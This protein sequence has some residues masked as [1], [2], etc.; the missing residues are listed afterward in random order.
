MR[1]LLRQL[2]VL[3]A[4]ISCGSASAQ[5]SHTGARLR[6][7]SAFALPGAASIINML[8]NPQAFEGS[9]WV[10]TNISDTTFATKTMAPDGT[11]TAEKLIANTERGLHYVSYGNFA[12]AAHSVIYRLMVDAKPAEYSRLNISYAD[13]N[14]GSGIQMVC[15]FA[16]VRVG[17]APNTFGINGSSFSANGSPQIYRIGNGFARCIMDV[18]TDALGT[19][20]VSIVVDRGTGRGALNWSFAGN[21]SKGIFVWQA[22]LL[23]KAVW[24]Q[25]AGARTFF[26]PMTSSSTFDL[27]NSKA[28]GYNWY[29]NNQWPNAGEPA[30]LGYP[31]SFWRTTTPTSSGNLSFGPGGVTIATDVSPGALNDLSTSVTNNITVAT[32]GTTAAG[33]AILHFASV[34]GSI[35]A[36]MQVF[37]QQSGD[38]Y[39]IIPQN[40]TV[41]SATPTTV[42]LS[43]N[44][45]GAGV[46]SGDSIGFQTSPGYIGQVFTGPALF[47]VTMSFDPATALPADQSWPGFFGIAS[48]FLSGAVCSA[49]PEIDHIEM[50]PSGTGTINPTVSL[51]NWGSCTGT[52]AHSRVY[53][54]SINA[55]FGSPTY[56]N[57]NRFSRLWL[58]ESIGAGGTGQ[59]MLQTYFNGV[60]VG[61]T[62]VLYSTGGS[63]PS[64]TSFASDSFH[65]PF[66]LGTGPGWPATF[67]NAQVWQ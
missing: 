63:V 10:K 35:V 14:G 50:I 66:I 1:Q 17:V 30:G 31:S 36:G 29:L 58:P 59:A 62:E 27:T 37:E 26:D 42:T 61:G 56:T 54:T 20:T 65:M 55:G 9:T 22:S 16:S 19:G 41:L 34:P 2:C 23:P 32:N 45:I 5:V 21:N 64:G 33:S 13:L 52:F 7:P 46:G 51:H 12:H 60:Y 43:A 25:M 48:E 47:D 15:D 18:N 38:P 57:P 49:Y 28:S 8:P 40:T 67:A 4:F 11:K 39:A 53:L 3:G 44:V 6:A 24:T